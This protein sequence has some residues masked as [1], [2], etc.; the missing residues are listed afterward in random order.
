MPVVMQIIS[1]AAGL[2]EYHNGNYLEDYDPNANHGMGV[3]V[4]CQDISHAKRFSDTMAALECWKAVSL[5][6][7]RRNDGKPNRPL[8][9]YNIVLQQV[10]E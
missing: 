3:I 8:T 10:S 5:E 9:A 1:D 7:P 2:T 6:R 4:S